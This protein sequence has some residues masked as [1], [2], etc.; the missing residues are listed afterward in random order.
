[1]EGEESECRVM[2][3]GGGVCVCRDVGGCEDVR[4]GEWGRL[5]MG[6]RG[7]SRG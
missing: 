1:M 5:R 2:R 4:R 6:G 3:V 7:G